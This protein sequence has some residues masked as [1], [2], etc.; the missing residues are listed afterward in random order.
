MRLHQT[1]LFLLL[2][3]TATAA[4]GKPG[5]DEIAR[6]LV[7]TWTT[8]MTGGSATEADGTVRYAKDGT[9]HAAGKVKL[10]GGE[11]ADVTV[12]GTWEVKGGAVKETVTKSSHPG[13]AP[14]G[15]SIQEKVLAIDDKELTVKRGLG[16]ERVRKRVEK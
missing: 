4:D 1:V 12:D 6:K 2:T 5:D 7:G 10:G 9:F 8:C 14:V 15:A 3:G 16:E 11:V 13:L